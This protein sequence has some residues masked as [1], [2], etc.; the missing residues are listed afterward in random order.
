MP[1]IV[2]AMVR[3]ESRILLTFFAIVFIFDESVV[4]GIVKTDSKI[5]LIICNNLH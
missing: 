2:K 5:I 3:I 1:A 4:S